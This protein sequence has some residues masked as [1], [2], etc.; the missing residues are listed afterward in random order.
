MLQ[1]FRSLAAAVIGT[2]ALSTAAV[3]GE[4]WIA[5]YDEA[6]KVATAEKKD[7]FVDFTGSDWCGWCKKLDKEVFSHE[8]FL[9]EVKK[10]FV[11]VSLDFPQAKEVKAKVPNPKRNSE[12]QDKYEIQGFPTILLMTTDGTVF[13]QTGYRPGGP[14]KYVEHVKELRTKGRAAL[15]EIQALL[16]EYGKAE[17]DARVKVWDKVAAA[18][19]KH[20]EQAAVAKM[21]V[22][23]L[24]D[25]LT[26]DKDNKAGRKMRALELLLKADMGDEAMIAD[27]RALDP[28]NEKGL[29][30]Y[31]V[32][33]AFSSVND[34]EGAKAAL[35]EL[36]KLDALGA[37]KNKELVFQ[38]HFMAAQWSA[39]PLDD[40]A[41]AKKY[42]A[43]AK[44]IGSDEKQMLEKLDE[45][46]N[47]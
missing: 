10:D 39:G 26:T 6:V 22:P 23:A 4:G 27:A 47:S 43:A 37:A 20:S 40:Q 28:K 14:A 38:L 30:E 5:D 33:A 25:A 18:F 12:L 11:L 2:L 46:L 41:R 13:G 21:L 9:N 36:D 7:L 15:T 8:E 32:K 19:E 34:D 24:K 31:V 17:G 1:S 3:A 45:I 16:A 42:A 44:A 35:D 29:M